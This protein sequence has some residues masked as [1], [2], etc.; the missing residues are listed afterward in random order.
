MPAEGKKNNRIDDLT[1]EYG[2][3]F[4][5][6]FDFLANIFN[7]L[8]DVFDVLEK[9]FDN[10][11]IFRPL[12]LL[13][14]IGMLIYY[15]ASF[16][17]FSGWNMLVFIYFFVGGI[18]LLFMLALYEFADFFEPYLLY[19]MA[20]RKSR[21]ESRRILETHRIM[22]QIMKRKKKHKDISADDVL[23]PAKEKKGA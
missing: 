21:E 14:I 13:S 7:S 16:Q 4:S 2:R 22:R 23:V 11:P 1:S 18:V 12:V 3:F 19:R 5:S 8:D 6:I 20:T 17:T 10:I 9:A 15:V